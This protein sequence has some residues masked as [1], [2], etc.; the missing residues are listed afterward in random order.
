MRLEI[1]HFNA[2]N[3]HRKAPTLN[4]L[5]KDDIK[6]VQDEKIALEAKK[7]VSIKYYKFVE[8]EIPIRIKSLANE[9]TEHWTTRSKRNRS[10]GGAVRYYLQNQI[11]GLKPPFLITLTRIAPRKFDGDNLVI[12]FKK[13]RDTISHL[14]FPDVKIGLADSYDCFVWHYKQEKGKPKNILSK[15]E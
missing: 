13:I 3:S 8:V 12:S 7:T 15:L 10:H 4:D 11:Y 1:C 6:A 9:T 2:R 5:S 14:F